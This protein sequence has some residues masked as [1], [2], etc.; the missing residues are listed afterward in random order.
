MDRNP[1]GKVQRVLAGPAGEGQRL[2][3]FLLRALAG[4]PR[5]RVYRLLRRGEVRV[6]GKRKQADYRLAADDEVRLPPVREPRMDGQ[7]P[8]AVP[9]GLLATVRTAIVHEDE[10]VLVLNKPAGLAVHGGS[11]LAFGAIE[12]LRALRPSESL[13]LAHRLDR[14]TSGCLLV[15]RTRPA[16]RMLHALLREGEV[17]KHYTALV[18]GRWRLGRKT[19]DAP[20]LTNARQGG[21]RVVRVH[22]E[23]KIA[24]SVF[25]P[26]Q[27][28]RDL[29][30]R[31]DVAIQT[32]RTHQIRV[33][34][35]FAGHPIAG[36]EKYGDRDFNARMREL[37]LRRMFL[38]AASVSFAWPD[39]KSPFK[40]SAELPADLATLLAKLPGGDRAQA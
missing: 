40:V 37:G 28:Y 25:A 29:A 3:N 38:H 12:A 9:D 32:G 20:V 15:A 16:L 23:G 8:R 31:M 18:A 6:N 36:D 24:I 34:A 19:I 11:G 14:D 10:R 13:E 1:P 27:H 33:H 39:T 7:A 5:S 17:E 2:D 30:T 35:R 22:A 21:E 4:V 26:Q